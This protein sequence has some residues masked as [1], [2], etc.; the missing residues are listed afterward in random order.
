MENTARKEEEKMLGEE[1]KIL[2]EEKKI[3]GE[4]KKILGME[5]NYFIAAVVVLI[6]IIAMT[7]FL[8]FKGGSPTT[9]ASFDNQPV[10]SGLINELRIPDSV[11]GAVGMGQ[12]INIPNRTLSAARW[13]ESGKP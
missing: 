13:N 2:V 10:P 7:A 11:S 3:L 5:R 1:K 8:G 9:L 12:V 6:A 4:E